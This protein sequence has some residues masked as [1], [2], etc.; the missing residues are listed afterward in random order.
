MQDGSFS[1]THNDEEKPR[2]PVGEQALILVTAYKDGKSY[3]SITM[4]KITE[5]QRLPLELLETSQEKLKEA[6]MR[7]L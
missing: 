5:G 3:S 7:V 4:L 6:L 1:F 2:L